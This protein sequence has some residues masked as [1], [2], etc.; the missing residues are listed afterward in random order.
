MMHKLTLF[1]NRQIFFNFKIFNKLPQCMKKK[2]EMKQGKLKNG[3]DVYRFNFANLHI[4]GK[5]ESQY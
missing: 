4:P 1:K 3:R 5:A 2:K